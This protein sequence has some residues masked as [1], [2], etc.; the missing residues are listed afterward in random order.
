MSACPRH[1]LCMQAHKRRGAAWRRARRARREL[2]K[3]LTTATTFT[4]TFTFVLMRFLS[5]NT[6]NVMFYFWIILFISLAKSFGF[7]HTLACL[8]FSEALCILKL[9]HFTRS[10]AFSRSLCWAELTLTTFL[11][12]MHTF[13]LHFLCLLFPVELSKQFSQIPQ[14]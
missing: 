14:L 12:C 8:A 9:I 1:G 7:L 2:T 11:S 6:E 10:A 3:A 13:L 4:V 5:I